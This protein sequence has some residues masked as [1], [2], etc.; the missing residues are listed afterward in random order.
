MFSCGARAKPW[1][2]T[3]TKDEI[4]KAT[5][6]YNKLMDRC[7]YAVAGNVFPDGM[8]GFWEINWWDGTARDGN[9][10]FSNQTVTQVKGTKDV[11]PVWVGHVVDGVMSYT[12]RAKMC[13]MPMPL[14]SIVYEWFSFPMN[15]SFTE[16]WCIG[17]IAPMIGP[18]VM[19]FCQDPLVKKEVVD[20]FVETL[21]TKHGI[22]FTDKFNRIA[23][24][25]AYKQGEMGEFAFNKQGKP[26]TIDHSKNEWAAQVLAKPYPPP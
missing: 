11:S 25:V 8:E 12:M 14:G 20:A 23:W 7:W 18:V 21:K 15:D 4:L 24:P 9:A 16:F 19:L 22:A 13:G 17:A 3:M 26:P 2:S 5:D 10:V 1:H 6:N